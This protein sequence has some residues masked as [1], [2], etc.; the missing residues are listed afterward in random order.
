MK[1]SEVLKHFGLVKWE[2]LED[3]ILGEI[4]EERKRKGEK[5]VPFEE[6]W[7]K[8]NLEPNRN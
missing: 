1:K 3:Q 5:L 4:A 7:N 6:F 2:D 8:M